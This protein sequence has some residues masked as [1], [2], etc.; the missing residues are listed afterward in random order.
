MKITRVFRLTPI[1]AALISATSSLPVFAA[2]GLEE[3]LVT[4][5]R[6]TESSQSIGIAVSAIS[7]ETLRNAGVSNSEALTTLVPALVVQPSAGPSTQFYI[8]GVGSFSANAYAENAVAFQV[9]N[10][11]YARIGAPQGVFYDLERVE[12]LKGP[13][14]TL[15]GRNATG[16]AINVITKKPERGNTS[17]YLT[18]EAGNY[19]LLKSEGALNL[20]LTDISAMRF[21][22]QTTDRDGYLR[23][24]YDD[25]D[26]K[27]ARLQFVVD[28]TEKLSALLSVDYF[29]QGGRGRGSALFPQQGD[30]WTGG[31]DPSSLARVSP[32]NFQFSQNPARS[33]YPR[34]NGYNDNEYW[35]V[36]ATIDYDMDWAALTVL[37]AVRSSDMD[38]L[39]YV[40]GFTID[41]QEKADQQSLEIR[42]AS[43]YETSFDWVTGLFY[44][45]E[46]DNAHQGY[47]SGVSDTLINPKLET[48]SYAAF[49]QGTYHFTDDTRG[50]AGLRYTH[51]HKTQD[52]FFNQLFYFQPFINGGFLETAFPVVGDRTDEQVTWKL[53]VEHNVTADSMLYAH[54]ST[55]FKAGGFFASAGENT[56]KPEEITAYTI[57]SKNRFFQ[58]RLQINAELFYWDYQDQ[59]VSHLGPVSTGPGAYAPAFVT[60][61]VGNATMKGADVEFQA[62]IGDNDLLGGSVQY[63]ESEYTDFTYKY[64]GDAIP[65]GP[66]TGI[67][68]PPHVGCGVA[69][70]AIVNGGTGAISNVDCTGKPAVNAPLWTV[71][72]NYEHTFPSTV[73][74]FV[75]GARARYESERNLSVDYTDEVKVEEYVLL[76]AYL[77]FST[78]DKAWE[79]STYI[80]NIENQNVYAGSFSRPFYNDTYNNLRPPRT[81]GVRLTYNF[82]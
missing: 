41:T 62:L 70:E 46:S 55:G 63:L 66:G 21:A 60:E 77:N 8:R 9:D 15:Y 34:T 2:G 64:L 23:D 30:P 13:Q 50:I 11:Y 53:G 31:A 44:F 17:G 80:N 78:P 43:Q 54:V 7:E 25:D 59:Q 16:G 45:H 74:D 32:P 58:Q 47:L 22:F 68:I 20:P 81:Y 12:V 1:A 65:T 42:L 79:V 6:Q 36:A 10:I 51:E 82:L 49:G 37:P 67:P 76:D 19:A 71:N 39:S 57:G 28:P 48:T 33:V 14:G 3:I 24:G 61:N 29:K 38:Y 26:G 72:L 18:V 40:A 5:Q 69:T 75:F 73:G 56:F 27:A 35:G 4:S 52:T